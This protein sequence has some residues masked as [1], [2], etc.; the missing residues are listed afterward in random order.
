MALIDFICKA[1]IARAMLKHSW[2]EN[3]LLNKNAED[4][5]YLRGNSGWNALDVEFSER[6]KEA[7]GLADDMEDGFSPAQL[8]DYLAPFAMVDQ[9]IRDKIKQAIHAAYLESS[10]IPDFRVPLREA[11]IAFGESLD[12]LREAWRL[13]LIEKNEQRLR[14]SW[15][16]V[17]KRAKALHTVLEQLP[18]G[19]VLP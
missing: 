4:I 8:V 7:I 15:K 19:V 16:K 3:Q 18:K 2:L 1:D 10:N 5:V 12:E 6:V 17:S 14:N 13:P 9:E 11:A